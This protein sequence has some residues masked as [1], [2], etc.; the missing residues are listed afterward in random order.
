MCA[1]NSA[2]K[3][4]ALV[5]GLITVAVNR[6]ATRGS[7][8]YTGGGMGAFSFHPY[9]HFC[10]HSKVCFRPP[11]WTLKRPGSTTRLFSALKKERSSGPSSKV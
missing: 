9:F 1:G 6:S 10:F 2:V 5:A 7:N 11:I 3:S 8:G 4:R